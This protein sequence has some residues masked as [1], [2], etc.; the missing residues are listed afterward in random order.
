MIGV[1]A[2]KA[3]VVEEPMDRLRQRVPYPRR[4]RDHVRPR[5][6]MRDLAQELERVR[7]GLNR[8]RI[9]VVDPADHLDRLRLH[10]ERLPLRRRRHDRPRRLHRAAGRELQDLVGVIG[11]RIRRDHLQRMKQRSIRQVRTK[12]RLSSRAGCAPSP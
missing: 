5:P 6:Q 2:E 3:V 11:Q 7:L 12:C 10:L 9:R 1:L 8:I 4:R